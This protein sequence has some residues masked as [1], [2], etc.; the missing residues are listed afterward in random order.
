MTKKSG[1]IFTI[2]RA[3]VLLIVAAAVPCSAAVTRVVVVKVDGM[4]SA[5]VSRFVRERDQR[6]GKSQLPWIEHVFYEGGTRLE[7]FYV[8][9]MSLS[10]PS[11]SLLDTGQHLQIK[12]NVEFDRYTLRSYDYLNFIPFYINNAMARR[13]DMPGT[14]VLDD[15][16]NPL[17]LDAYPYS[18]RQQSFQLFQ[19]GVRWTTLQRGLKDRLTSRTPRELFDEWTIGFDTNNI[20]Y[21]RLERELIEKLQN[22]QVRYL[23][24]YTTEFDHVAH[25]NR[26]TATQLHALREADQLVGRIW[27]AIRRS[28]LAKETALILVSDHG[29]NSNEQVYS[30]GYN[31]VKLLASEAGGAHHVVTKRRLLQDYAVKGFYPLTPL[32]TTVAPDS[33]YLKGQSELYPTAVL[34]FDGNERASIH[35]RDSDL[36]LLHILFR[37]LADARL[38]ATVKAAA[39]ETFFNVI[40]SRRSEW[41]TSLTELRDELGAL[42][43]Q[44]ETQLALFAQQPKKWTLADRDAGRDKEARRIFARAD[45][46]GAEEATYLEYLRTLENLLALRRETFNPKRLKA[47]DLFPHRSM[48][49]HNS[50][51]QLQN[52]IVGIA[53]SG[54]V[55]SAGNNSLDIERSFKRINYFS[56][57]HNVA[58][59][60]NVQRGVG[61]RPVDFVAVRV[62]RESLRGQLANDQLPD[63]DA[64]WLYGGDERQA[65]IFA[66]KDA[67]SGELSLR[68]L[69]VAD[70]KQESNGAV[71]F[72]RQE[73]SEN[74][75]LRMFEDTQLQVPQGADRAAWLSSWHT[76]LEWLRATHKCHYSNAL[77]GLHEQLA[78]HTSANLDP[79]AHGITTDEK[80]LRRLK[81]RERRLAEADLLILANDHWNFDV[82][83]FNPGGNH[84]SFFR[85]STHSVF[86]IAGGENTNIPRA[87]SVEEPYDSLSLVPTVLT[88]TGELQEGRLSP[89]LRARGFQQFPGRVVDEVVRDAVQH[90]QQQRQPT[91]TK[92]GISE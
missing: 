53:P 79:N 78:R 66:R 65:L 47:E 68:Y 3:F 43:R 87:L 30:Q 48:G 84:G 59:R 46:A 23:D 11:W 18:A 69:P 5:L 55:M 25:N 75:P 61:N 76:E 28:P 27:T 56:L 71:S 21:E 32:I 8:R 7:N 85:I 37:Q 64:I 57:I 62:A 44:T 33:T 50:L 72:T 22:S 35:L 4:P 1:A 92:R 36:N 12:G 20:V 24:F 81:S 16:G 26:E 80:L 74:F 51:R 13:V 63:Q 54:L 34:D 38:D 39:T 6:T 19:R 41:Q 90:R 73:W 9:G 15:I 29:T 2:A 58:V 70:L 31:L 17:L 60:N 88:L 77:I 82:K 67:L 83:G 14:E 10:G 45:I 91:A 42:R 49:E 40:E 89:N 86:M 52:Y